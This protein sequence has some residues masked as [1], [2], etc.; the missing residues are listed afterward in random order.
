MLICRF[1]DPE[2]FESLA[3][4]LF[5]ILADNMT[6]IAPTGCTREEDFALWHSSMLENLQ[7]DERC[8]LLAEQ[9]GCL[10]GYLQ[11]SLRG[12][13]LLMEE[14]EIREDTQGKG[15]FR[16][17]YSAL[18]PAVGDRA[19]YTEAYANKANQKSIGILGKLG[20]TVIGENK[21][22]RSWHFRGTM[23]ALRAW[24]AQK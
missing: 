19:L 10:V 22:G 3:R 7:S 13:T 16:A 5:D 24:H 12:D 4:P 6:K 15:V 21:S 20:L 11:Y 17:L 14:I 8:I 23:A 1:L 18:L 2:Q 9:D